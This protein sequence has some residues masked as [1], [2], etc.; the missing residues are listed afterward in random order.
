V[1]RVVSGLKTNTVAVD[2]SFI[3][4]FWFVISIY[5]ELVVA[6]VFKLGNIDYSGSDALMSFSGMLTITPALHTKQHILFAF[7][8]LVFTNHKFLKLKILSLFMFG[9]MN[10]Y[11]VIAAFIC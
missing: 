6:A 8:Q 1:V 10:S 4:I 2:S 5:F 9:L 3:F 11:S 7:K